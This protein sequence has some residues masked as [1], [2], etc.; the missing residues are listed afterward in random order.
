M[1]RLHASGIRIALDD[2]GTGYSSLDYLR[3]LPL[4]QLKMDRSFIS[5]IVVNKRSAS[6]ARTIIQLGRDLDMTVLAEGVET[7]EQLQFL[8]DHGCAE[9]QGFLL[10]RPVP[11]GDFDQ[12][13]LA[14][15]AWDNPAFQISQS[16]AAPRWPKAV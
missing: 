15:H 9:F 12:Q 13:T 6:L 4:D 7:Q 14:N 11:R 8:L 1:Q 2:F 5:D 16:I 3:R 10:G